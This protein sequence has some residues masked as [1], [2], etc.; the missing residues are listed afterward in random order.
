[1][2]HSKQQVTKVAMVQQSGPIP[3]VARDKPGQS[4]IGGKMLPRTHGNFCHASFHHVHMI[5][6]RYFDSLI[7][8]WTGAWVLPLLGQASHLWLTPLTSILNYERRIK[9]KSNHSI[10]LVDPNQPLTKQHID[11]GLSLCHSS[12]PSSTYYFP[13]PSSRPKYGEV[14]CSRRSHN[15]TRGKT[16]YN[17]SKYRT[18]TKFTWLL[19]AWLIPC[20]QEQK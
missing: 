15:T 11:W 7:C 5:R 14:L 16:T 12:N 2:I 19:I 6:V 13:M 3:F 18:N 17:T 20:P 1:M 9:T 4:L 10:K 8:G